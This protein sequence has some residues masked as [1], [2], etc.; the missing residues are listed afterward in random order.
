[1][2]PFTPHI[3]EELWKTILGHPESIHRQAWITYNAEYAKDDSITLVVQVNGKV[4]ARINAP[5]DVNDEQARAL[6]VAEPD[7]VKFFNGA[8]PKQV[9]YVK[10]RGIINIVM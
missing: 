10:G 2:A 4:R 8:T 9:I 3:T 1:M 7:V 6:A 5:A